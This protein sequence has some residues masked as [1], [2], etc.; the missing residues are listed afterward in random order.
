MR[1]Y[2]TAGKKYCIMKMSIGPGRG[3]V[4]ALPVSK[5][6]HTNTLRNTRQ[7]MDILFMPYLRR[8]IL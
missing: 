1:G 2:F 3:A 4:P 8:E 6:T 5:L 7:P